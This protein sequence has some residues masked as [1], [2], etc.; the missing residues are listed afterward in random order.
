MAIT[1]SYD[2]AIYCPSMKEKKTLG[3]TDRWFLCLYW[4]TICQENMSKGSN[5]Q[6]Y[7]HLCNPGSW[8]LC[9]FLFLKKRKE[10]GKEHRF[11][12]LF[13]QTK[14]RNW[15][16]IYLSPRVSRATGKKT[17]RILYRILGFLPFSSSWPR[18]K[19]NSAMTFISSPSLKKAI[20]R[21]GL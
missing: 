13:V 11:L 21:P 20:D 9:P 18:G 6:D 8:V 15:E 17:G 2:V 4:R 1:F 10:D 14:R 5:I 3:H 19:G 16:E 12:P 7:C